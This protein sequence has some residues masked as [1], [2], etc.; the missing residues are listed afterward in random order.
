LRAGI[1]PDKILQL[2][3]PDECVVERATGLKTDPATGKI[4]HDI[5][6]P[7]PQSNIIEARLV[8]RDCDGEQDVKTRLAL[9]RKNIGPSLGC[10]PSDRVKKITYPDGFY[11]NEKDVLGQILK[12]SGEQTLSKAPR[13]YKI[14]VSGLP[15]MLLSFQS[16]L[17]SGK[18][19]VAEMLSKSKGIVHVSPLSVI[20]EQVSANTA[21]GI[22][23]E[24][25]TNKPDDGTTLN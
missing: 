16:T 1:V 13:E 24:S 3:V 15:G 10:F 8:T 9:Y 19:S 14:V 6:D 23:L 18:T 2:D 21:L 22:E 4:Y 20:L 5:L 11:L 25:F 17:G 12:I 7:P